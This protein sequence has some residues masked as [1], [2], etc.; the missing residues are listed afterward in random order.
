MVGT[1]WEVRTDLHTVM[2]LRPEGPPKTTPQ[3]V[4]QPSQPAQSASPVS[5][6]DPP[7]PSRARPVRPQPGAVRRDARARGAALGAVAPRRVGG[8]VDEDVP[9][10]RG[11]TGAEPVRAE[12]ADQGGQPE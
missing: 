5:Q 8:D 3:P 7:A 9:T 4:S 2:N 6:P 1:S 11:R 10:G 12:V